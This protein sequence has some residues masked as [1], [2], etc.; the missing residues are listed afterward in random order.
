MGV[1]TYK[2]T[3]TGDLELNTLAK[4]TVLTELAAVEQIV[5]N[6]FS[7]WLG[8]WFRDRTRGVDWINII[9][10][11]VNKNGIIQILAT[12]LLKNIYITEI[13]DLSLRVNK[14]TRVAE[15]NYIIFTTNNPEEILTG[16]EQIIEL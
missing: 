2:L 15:I 9:T 3:D 13:V 10:K 1:L 7:L 12:A 6:T 11:Q 14:Q 8:E 4:P 16:T 5:K